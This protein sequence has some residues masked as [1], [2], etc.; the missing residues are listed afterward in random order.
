MFLS[1]F[2]LKNKKNIN[3]LFV[4]DEPYNHIAVK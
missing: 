4:D 3:I 2:D 1:D